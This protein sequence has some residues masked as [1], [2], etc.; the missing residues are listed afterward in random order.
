MIRYHYRLDPATLSDS[1]FLELLA[2]Y[3]FCQEQENKRMLGILRT[4]FSEALQ[5][6]FGSR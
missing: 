1:E 4:V 3:T 2:E 5:A 6:V